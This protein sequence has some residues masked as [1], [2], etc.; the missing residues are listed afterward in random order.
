M[1]SKQGVSHID[2][3]VIPLYTLYFFGCKGVLMHLNCMLED[4][5]LL[6]TKLAHPK[7]QVFV[8]QFAVG[9][10]DMVVFDPAAGNCAIYEIKHSAE[11][12]P[13]QYHH[14]VDEKKCELTEHRY[15]PITSKYVLY[16]GNDMDTSHLDRSY[17]YPQTPQNLSTKSARAV[18][19]LSRP[20]AV[21]LSFWGHFGVKVTRLLPLFP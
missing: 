3:C 19:N 15:G 9:E 21:V 5:V 12:V 20:G 6:G 14:L 11:A 7:K 13:S 16:R 2:H 10:F 1:H 4:I 18:E 17:F 8:L